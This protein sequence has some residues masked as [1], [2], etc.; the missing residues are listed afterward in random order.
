MCKLCRSDR[1]V[2][3]PSAATDPLRAWHISSLS[4]SSPPPAA[5]TARPAWWCANQHRLHP[6]PSANQHR[7][8]PSPSATTTPPTCSAYIHHTSRSLTRRTRH[9][10]ASVWSPA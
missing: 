10:G 1:G 3:I 2:K 9:S 4:P 6:S 7:L 8:H 5:A